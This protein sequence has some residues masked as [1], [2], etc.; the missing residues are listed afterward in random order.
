[1]SKHILIASQTNEFTI[2][3]AEKNSLIFSKRHFSIS[4][5]IVFYFIMAIVFMSLFALYYVEFLGI[6]SVMSGTV[7]LSGF[8]IYRYLKPVLELNLDFCLTEE[9][10][11]EINEDLWK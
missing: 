11:R 3:K 8:S 10:Q 9:E 4:K 7:L 1:M 2:N 6:L 5:E